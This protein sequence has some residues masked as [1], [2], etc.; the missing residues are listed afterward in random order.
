MTVVVVLLSFVCTFMAVS[1]K[2]GEGPRP[3]EYKLREAQT[4][5]H[6]EKIANDK[7]FSMEQDSVTFGV[8]P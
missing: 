7:N 1:P 8:R 3:T 2:K 4:N 6:L 5:A